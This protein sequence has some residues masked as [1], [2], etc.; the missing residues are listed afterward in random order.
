VK[1]PASVARL[2]AT[3]LARCGVQRVYGLCGG[4][5][6][7]IWNELDL[8]GI[9]IV[10]VR[11]EASAVY[12][13]HAEAEL[14]GLVGV[15]MI[16]AG[17][18]L[19]NAITAIANAHVART[20]VL[21]ISGR[22]PR[23]QT[24]MGALQDVPQ[25]ALVAPI[26]RRVEVVTER[27]HVL[28][29]L[30]A[31]LEAARGVCGPS[32]P[33][34]IDFPTDLLDEP[35]Y[36]AD[37]DPRYLQAH[38]AYLVS[39]SATELARAAEL[40][41]MA[42]RP[43]VISGRGV[44]TARHQLEA[45]LEVS[46]ALYLDT[47]E[48][49]GT[50]PAD[51]PAYV[52]A[53]R[54][55]VMREADVVITLGRRLDFQ[56]AYGSPAVFSPR[57]AFVRIGRTSDETSE[58][59]RGDAEV[60]AEPPLALQRLVDL[61]PNPAELDTAWRESVI[62]ENAA[63]LSRLVDTM[64]TAEQGSDGR[65]HPYTLIA[66]L[67]RHIDD[68]TVVVADG[69]DILSFARVGLKAPT[70]LDCGA[71]GCLGVGVPFATAAALCLADRRVIALVGDGAFGLTAMDVNS[72]ARH[73]A[74]AVFVIANN[75]AWNIERHDQL[76]RYEGNVVGVDLPGC[77][78]DLVARGLGVHAEH[79][80]RPQELDA[81]L[82]RALANAPA[83]V[84]VAVTRDAVSPDTASGLASVPPRHALRTWNQAELARHAET[85]LWESDAPS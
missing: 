38:A 28:P 1:R 51:H 67:N 2:I 61:R 74:K 85:R 11:H 48:S 69:G 39:P 4:H 26:C 43:L 73:H 30:D 65:M 55:R 59:R 57:T 7:P 84:D 62:A 14:T 70:Y 68:G 63:K 53:L 58:G 77:R 24:G 17:P 13:A 16:T 54:S 82:L 81:A 64:A 8:L 34:Y 32:G 40:I 29:R 35:V 15:A 37:V 27:H 33:A 42:R 23:P 19:T 31:A 49:R 52:P 72:A 80:T 36:Q 18:G 76:Q 71:L 46:G 78:Y 25:G 22:P 6:Q 79:V 12:M 41:R 44:S 66:A 10:D 21:I 75:E 47:S 20:P 45:F 60:R 3:Y 83:V 9:R 50:V 56:L 5:V